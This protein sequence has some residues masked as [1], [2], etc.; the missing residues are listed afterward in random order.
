M[1]CI[2]KNHT[3]NCATQTDYTSTGTCLFN[4]NIIASNSNCANLKADRNCTRPFA[5]PYETLKNDNMNL[6]CLIECLKTKGLKIT[7]YSYNDTPYPLHGFKQIGKLILMPYFL[8]NRIMK[9]IAL[10]DFV[11]C[12]PIS[13]H[14][15]IQ[16]NSLLV[17][18]F[19]VNNCE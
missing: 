4:C 19:G 10:P 12:Y 2:S 16:L 11:C 6:I 17:L 7:L 13:G 8:K 5:L 9:C 18:N 3:Q 14:V 1:S 15:W